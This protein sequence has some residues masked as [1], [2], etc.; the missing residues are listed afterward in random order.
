MVELRVSGLEIGDATL[1]LLLRHMPQL[2][3]LDLAHCR[4]ISDQSICLLTSAGSHSRNTLTH[5]TLTGTH[6]HTS[7][8]LPASCVI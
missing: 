5:I 7:V 3:R 1:R 8:C 2:E 6:A 4:D